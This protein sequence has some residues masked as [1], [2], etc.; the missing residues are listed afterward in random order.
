MQVR[1]N[2]IV[3]LQY[4]NFSKIASTTNIKKLQ[5]LTI[6]PNPCK[7]ACNVTFPKN[8]FQPFP[9]V[10]N[11]IDAVGNVVFSKILI[12]PVSGISVA[13]L[14]PGFYVVSAGGFSGKIVVE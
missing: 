7:E 3:I 5:S 1:V 11:V 6:F 9:I 13:G 10:C 12:N 14:K 2:F 4:V 8:T